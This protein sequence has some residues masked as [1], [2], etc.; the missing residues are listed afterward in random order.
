[1]TEEKMTIGAYETAYHSGLLLI[2]NEV[3]V[4]FIHLDVNFFGKVD[5]EFSSNNTFL[6]YTPL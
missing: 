4:L 6:D 1:M 5:I 2:I 3:T